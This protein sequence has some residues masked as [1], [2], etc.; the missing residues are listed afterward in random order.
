MKATELM[1]GDYLRINR[2]RLCIKKGTIVEVRGIDAN[3]SLK[4]LIGCA[5]CRPLD[6][7]QYEGGIWC[8]YLEPI[9]ITEEILK[10]NGFEECYEGEF[11]DAYIFEIRDKNGFISTNVALSKNDDEWESIEI[12]GPNGKIEELKTAYIHQLQHALK[13]C[14]IEKEITI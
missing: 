10:K 6:D 5:T 13:L 8:D 3:A 7:M 9:P 12:Y 14:G 1:I 11:D 2:D 4:N